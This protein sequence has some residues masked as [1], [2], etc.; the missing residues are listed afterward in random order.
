MVPYLEAPPLADGEL[1][2]YGLPAVSAERGTLYEHCARA[3]DRGL[4]SGPHG[5]PLIGTGDWND[6]MNRV[7][8]R[9]RGESVWLGW[10]LSKILQEFAAIAR[11]RG[12][13]D[14]AR[15]WRGERERLAS[16]LELAWDGDWYRR[17]YFDDGTPL[18]S[19]QVPE[20]RIDSISQSWA[21]LSG[22]RNAV[23]ARW[24][25][26]A[27]TARRRRRPAADASICPRRIW[28]IRDTCRAFAKWGPITHFVGS[29]GDGPA[30]ERRRA[31]ELFHMLNRSATRATAPTAT[32]WSYVVA[33]DVYTHPCTSDAAVDVVRSA[34][35]PQVESILASPPG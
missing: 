23:G 18:G 4:S 31:V 10:F 14:H 27:R 28:P 12:D 16:H 1:E 20:C 19:A 8:H 35:L 24:T 9:G 34:A 32:R 21:V 22:G 3:I 7:G 26:V 2:A 15:R 33:A 17:A 6:G 11:V 5:L 30:R 13:L 29:D 25:C